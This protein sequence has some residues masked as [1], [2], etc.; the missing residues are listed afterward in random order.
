MRFDVITI[1]PN[2]FDALDISLL[3]KAQQTGAL[4]VRVHNLRDWARGKHLSVDDT[5]AGGGAGMV[6]RP[7]VWGSAI[8]AALAAPLAPAIATDESQD[9]GRGGRVVAIPTPAGV[10]LTQAKLKELATADQVIIA[11]GRY[12]GIDARVAQYYRQQGTEVYEFS[13]GDYVLNGG[14]VAALA[15]IEG[16]ARLLEGFMGNPDSLSEESH[17]AES[18]LE[19]PVYTHPRTWHGLETPAVLGSGDHGKIRAWRR[20]ESLKRTAAVRPDLLRALDVGALSGE[21]RAYLASLGYLLTPEF[22]RVTYRAAEEQDLDQL[23]ALAR[24]TFPD[25]C[26][27]E[28]TEEDIA[29]H[30]DREF[31]KDKF[32][33]HMN[34]P[35]AVLWVASTSSGL[36]GYCLIFR[37]APQG[38]PE[39]SKGAGY[40]SKCYTDE[41]YRGSGLTAAL[42]ESSI[43]EARDRWHL[44]SLTLATHIGNK[45][46]ARFYKKRGFKKRGRRH[47]LVGETDNIDDVFV[48]EFT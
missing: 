4:E 13:L 6:M 7:D 33:A 37:E 47:F 10:P 27:P 5:P 36:A 34:D 39:V 38:F 1:F 18:L 15:L 3:G 12:E 22:D 42:L 14:E 46:A 26:P 23:S 17:S 2:Y 40:V 19:Y 21:D 48:R 31:S 30:V 41:R 45:R 43:A 29:V 9:V 20:E 44:P 35:Q 16:T 8:D 28:V 32:R 24:R 25:A 11:C